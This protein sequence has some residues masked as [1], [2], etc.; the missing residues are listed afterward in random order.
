MSAPSAD[1]FWDDEP[2]SANS[3]GR[4]P[5]L[6]RE[7]SRQASPVILGCL[8]DQVPRRIG[9]QRGSEK[10]IENQ[11][12]KVGFLRVFDVEV[13]LKSFSDYDI[14]QHCIIFR[15]EAEDNE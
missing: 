4:F 3:S 14:V 13:V 11:P 7:Q 15:A 12:V 9:V 6:G 8:D 1:S 5:A 10:C 2:H